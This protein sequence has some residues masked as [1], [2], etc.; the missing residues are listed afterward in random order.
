MSSL[1]NRVHDTNVA[2][3]D[4]ISE[5]GTE[6]LPR[7]LGGNSAALGADDVNS[8]LFELE[9]YFLAVK[10]SSGKSKK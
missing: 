6:M 2:S 1:E 4:L 9:A 3:E 8:K 10:D 7:E 5:F